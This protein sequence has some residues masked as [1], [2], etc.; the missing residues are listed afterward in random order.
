MS[1][2]GVYLYYLESVYPFYQFNTLFY[3]ILRNRNTKVFLSCLFM[4][5]CMVPVTIKVTTKKGE[6]DFD[7]LPS[8]TFEWNCYLFIYSLLENYNLSTTISFFWDGHFVSLSN[9]SYDLN[10][11]ERSGLYNCL[12]QTYTVRRSKISVS[13]LS[14]WPFRY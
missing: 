13:E 1:S 14:S 3:K 8:F 4:C 11:L 2:V 12:Y 5:Q 9:V 10:K 6:L 7:D